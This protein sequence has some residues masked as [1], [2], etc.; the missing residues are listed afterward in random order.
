MAGKSRPTDSLQ[1][2]LSECNPNVGRKVLSGRRRETT[3]Q[4]HKRYSPPPRRLDRRSEHVPEQVWGFARK[5][6]N[7]TGLDRSWSKLAKAGEDLT[8]VGQMCANF[9]QH[10]PVL[11]KHGPKLAADMRRSVKQMLQRVFDECIWRYSERL[12]RDWRN[13]E[14]I[15]IAV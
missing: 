9:G 13:G 3:T 5:W 11:A 7:L 14:E 8:G 12:S 4:L 1:C 6:P 2:G 15:W 10:R